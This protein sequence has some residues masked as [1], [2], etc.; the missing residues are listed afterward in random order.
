MYV[1][2]PGGLLNSPGKK[3]AAAI[4]QLIDRLDDTE[5]S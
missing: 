5:G 2:V 1:C 4:P 3:A